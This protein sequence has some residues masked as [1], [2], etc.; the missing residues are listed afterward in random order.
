MPSNEYHFITHWRVPSTCEE[1]TELLT[2]AE[3]WVRWWPS[4]Y[5]DIT[6]VDTIEAHGYSS[7]LHLYT[8]GWLP[9]TL[10]WTAKVV[11][12]NHPHGFRIEAAGDFVGTG[13]WTI[14]QDGLWVNVTYDWRIQADKA[15]LR[16]GSFLFRP[17]FEWN[18]RWAMRMGEE[19]LRLEL[20]RRRADSDDERATIPAPPGP[21]KAPP[22]LALVVA[23]A[24]LTALVG[25]VA[26]ARCRR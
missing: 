11:E 23:A 7:A 14:E 5:L 17:L 24:A 16:Y 18:H 26:R 8:K 1:I 3:D 4:V 13:V 19:S 10:R 22:T 2:N 12:T 9:Y 6:Q 20:A 25:S 21:T 15:L